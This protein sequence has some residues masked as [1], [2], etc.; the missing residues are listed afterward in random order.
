MNQDWFRRAKTGTQ[1]ALPL[2][3][4]L[5]LL[6]VTGGQERLNHWIYDTLILSAPQPPAAD[7]ALVTIDE[8]SLSA[9][10][11]WPWPRQR[12]AELIRRLDEAG[13]RTIV[14]D[15]LFSEPANGDDALAKAMRDHGRVVL[16]IHLYPPAA[17]RPLAEQLPTTA[18]TG[19]ASALGHAHV[20]LDGDGIARGLYLY[21]G[22]GQAY[23]PALSLATARASGNG[24]AWPD[25]VAEPGTAPIINVRRNYVRVPFAG[26]PERLPTTSYHDVLE[27]HIDANRFRGK[28]VFIGATAPGFG[29]VLPTPLSGHASPMSGVAFHANAWSALVQDAL[30]RPAPN[31]LETTLAL[32]VIALMSLL[33]PA[34]RPVTSFWFAM[35]TGAL[36]LLTTVIALRFLDLW[37]PS[38]GPIAVAWLAFPIWSARRLEMLNRFLK[39]Q[40]D[41][42][43]QDPGLRLNQA[44]HRTPERLLEDLIR[45]VRAEGWW[46]SHGGRVI[47]SR[48]MA[49]TTRPR[50][51]SD[52]HWTHIGP[53]SWI[54]WRQGGRV[55]EL[56][57][58]LPEGF[59]SEASRR[60]LQRVGVAPPFQKPARSDAPLPTE[61]ISARID[62]VRQ[63]LQALTGMREL[64]ARGFERMPDGIIV[65]DDLGNV[66]LVNGHVVH[67]FGQSHAEL[68][69]FPLAR[70][71]GLHDEEAQ[72][73]WK[74]TIADVLTLRETRTLGLQVYERDLLIHLAP[75]PLA[76][77]HQHG[78]I[79]SVADISEMREQ[80]R[81]HR[82]AIDFISHDVRSPLVSQLALIEQMKRRP[83]TIGTEQLDQ[84]GRLARRSYQ[85]AE[86]FVQLARAEQLTDDRFY[87][88]DFLSVVENARDSVSEQAA[89][90]NIRLVLNDSEDLWLE[91]NAELLERAIINLLTNAVQY[92]PDGGTITLQAFR[93]G[94]QASLTI[95]DEGAGIDRKELPFLFER[96]HRQQTTELAGN[97]GAGLGLSFVKVVIDKHHGEIDVRSTP[98][99]G[100]S[101]TIRLPAPP[102]PSVL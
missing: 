86:E 26:S 57:L 83:E 38:A 47:Q 54:R 10:G 1:L 63:A 79:A 62:Q 16:P 13:A 12:H 91:G 80:Q 71:L 56:G 8:A 93:A 19:A 97:H 41:L 32:L 87:D 34:L 5:L 94:H 60:Y 88:F 44:P 69:G 25:T 15:V 49:G 76:Q 78:I 35:M 70:L 53:E 11:R 4:A 64:I 65:T 68:E 14:L 46:L 27:G 52:G 36:I 72:E 96:F 22:M 74:E 33:L 61:S 75:F 98:G 18:L 82:Q 73:D 3:L 92:S 23:W 59:H 37:L 40:L 51:L 45:I 42:L 77:T 89:S 31:Y 67:W 50:A 84:L 6:H 39:R 28:V 99:E 9:L 101:F 55:Y 81:Q 66:Q 102:F 17:G 21:S 85:L 2:V 43:G 30:I 48:G 100:S 95:T 7:L 58:R 29:D 20:T 24:K 90:R